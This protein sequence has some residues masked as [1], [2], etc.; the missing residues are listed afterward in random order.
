MLVVLCGSI[1]ALSARAAID[2]EREEN[3]VVHFKSNADEPVKPIQTQLHEL[4]YVGAIRT[5]SSAPYFLFSGR[6]CADC[7]EDRGVHVIR[8]GKPG[9]IVTSFVYPGKILDPETK[10]LQLESRAFFGNCLP[11]KGDVY[12]VFQK[13]RLGKNGRMQTSVF[14]AEPA[15]DYLQE[16]LIERKLPK[17]DDAIRRVRSKACHE[18]NGRN[19]IMVSQPIDLRP[20]NK[21][22]T[23]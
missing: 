7:I 10:E 20:R 17:I 22:T 3:G 15:D 14:I 23:D 16:K 21:R 9:G 13:E 1:A 2:F 8:P 11:G 12:V 19:R 18:I 6:T 5:E 4:L